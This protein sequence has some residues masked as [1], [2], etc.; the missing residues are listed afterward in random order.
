MADIDAITPLENIVVVD[1]DL[2]K[3]RPDLTAKYLQSTVNQTDFSEQ[4]LQAKRVLH[5]DI[6]TNDGLSDAQ[7]LLVKDTKLSTM[8]D[9][10]VLRS[11]ANIMLLNDLDIMADTYS[12][13]A[14]KIQ[15]L[16]VLDSDEDNEQDASEVNLSSGPSFGR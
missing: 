16:Y 4:I 7:M 10:I 1:A 11:I 3:I 6:Q 9:K 15:T 2:L 12:K 8:K 13:D 14:A 5:V